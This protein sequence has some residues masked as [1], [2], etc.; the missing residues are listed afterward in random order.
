M[1]DT[2]HGFESEMREAE[3]RRTTAAYARRGRPTPPAAPSRHR[4]AERLRRVAD[5]LDG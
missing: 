5:R 3:I 1:S 4:L 2:L